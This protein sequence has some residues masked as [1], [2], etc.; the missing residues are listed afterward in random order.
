M[1]SWYVQVDP[2]DAVQ[3][4]ETA[5]GEKI[6]EVATQD[7]VEQDTLTVEALVSK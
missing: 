5:A 1:R 2:T 4:I 3:T 7:G 6:G